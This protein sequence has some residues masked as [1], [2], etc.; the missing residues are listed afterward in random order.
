ML[1]FKFNKK[2]LEETNTQYLNI[3]LLLFSDY[4]L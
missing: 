3:Q 2:C 1:A 4:S